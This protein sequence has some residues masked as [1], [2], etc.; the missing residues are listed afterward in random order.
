MKAII[1]TKKGAD[2]SNMEVKELPS[3][4][5]GPRQIKIKVAAS[6]VNPVDQ[7]LMKGMPFLRYQHPQIGGIDGSGTILE[8]GGQVKRFQAGDEVFFYRK[9]TDIGTWAEEILLDAQ[10]AALVPQALSLEEAGAV[11]LP[12]LTAWDA[13][14]QLKAQSGESILI[15]GAGGG[16]G[17]QAV[18]LARQLG[19]EVLATAGERDMA[20]LRKVGVSRIFNYKT[21]D[22]SLLLEAGELDYI[23]DVLGGEV[24]SKSIGLRPKKIVSTSLPNPGTMHKTGIRLPGI[25]KWVMKLANGKFTRPAKKLGVEL[26]GQVTGP[27]GSLM[28]EASKLAGNHHQVRPYPTLSLAQIEQAGMA[29]TRVGTV[30]TF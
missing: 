17:F 6:R 21:E 14:T 15:H 26:F 25:L 13:L 23:F 24:L 22:F 18:Q 5:P 28:E 19:L 20:D 10:D 1:R 16:V 11:A 7:G 4:T 30:I 27:H 29:G 8:V 3:P 9:F 12:M 2:F